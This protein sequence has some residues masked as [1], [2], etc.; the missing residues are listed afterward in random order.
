VTLSHPRTASTQVMPIQGTCLGH[1]L[2][3][4]LASDVNFTELLVPTDSVVRRRALSNYRCPCTLTGMP[5]QNPRS[6]IVLLLYCVSTRALPSHSTSVSR[7]CRP[8]Q[9][10]AGQ[11]LHGANSTTPPWLRA[12]L[13]SALRGRA[14]AQQ[15]AEVPAGGK[16]QLLHGDPGPGTAGEAGGEPSPRY[17]RS[18][19]R[20]LPSTYLVARRAHVDTPI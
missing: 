5:E 15:H 19:F 9:M 2:L 1:Q 7:H 16:Q 20:Y 11:P 14:V 17:F 10:Q 8:L 4:I 3:Q 12:Y 18:D 13:T 6:E